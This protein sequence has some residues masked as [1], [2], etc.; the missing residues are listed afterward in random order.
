MKLSELSVDRGLDVLANIIQHVTTIAADPKVTAL[1]SDRKPRES[2]T[3][4]AAVIRILGSAAPKLLTSHRAELIAILAE[5]EV[6]SAE[7]YVRNTSF[8]R[9]LGSLYEM[10]MDEELAALFTVRP[11]EGA[12]NSK[13]VSR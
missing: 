1:F 8:A 9:M 6:V 4:K 2:E 3:E 11:Y 12:E 7:E 13:A 5:L 10:M